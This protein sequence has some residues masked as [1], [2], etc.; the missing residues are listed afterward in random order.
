MTLVR[1]LRDYLYI[2]LGGNRRHVYLNYLLIFMAIALWYVTGSAFVIWGLWHGLGMCALRL[3]QNLWKKVG[4]QKVPGTFC[5]LQRWAGRH[6][7]TVRISS[8]LFT[9]HFVALGWLPFWG[10]HPQGLSMILRILS[11]NRWRLFEW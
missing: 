3:W 7:L 8:T 2:P 11:G 1:F 9:F 4:L 5:S 10:G 6:P